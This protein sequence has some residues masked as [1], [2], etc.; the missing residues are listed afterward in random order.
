[1]T[2]ELD[3]ES[4]QEELEPNSRVVCLAF[5]GLQPD[6]VVPNFHWRGIF[7]SQPVN[8]LYIRDV[9]QRFYQRGIPGAGESAGAIGEFMRRYM[10]ERRF[11]HS[12]CLG[13][14]AGG[15]AAMLYGWFIGADEVHAF[16]P[17]TRLPTR[18]KVQLLE[19]ILR[20][21]YKL[22]RTIAPLHFDR[23]IDRTYFDLHSVLERGNGRTLYHIYF[24]RG[25]QRD[26]AHARQ[27]ADIPG[28][29]LH[30][31]D[32]ADHHVS[33]MIRDSGELEQIIQES[34]T[35]YS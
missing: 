6:R 3:P 8:K 10:D 20:G 28:V 7:G 31:Y 16:A 27:L 32:T 35:R 17:L 13:G 33:T 5:T 23:G 11:E 19:L 24:G 2:I 14:S 30:E 12:L 34:I 29:V 25:H 4:F 1:M 18:S 15:Y 21:G 9:R 26:L 22:A